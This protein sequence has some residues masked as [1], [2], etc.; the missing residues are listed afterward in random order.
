MFGV[1]RYLLVA[2]VLLAGGCDG[3]RPAELWSTSLTTLVTGVATDVA[4]DVSDTFFPFTSAPFSAN[5]L[6]RANLASSKIDLVTEQSFAIAVRMIQAVKSTKGSLTLMCAQEGSAKLTINDVTI[7]EDLHIT[8]FAG[9]GDFSTTFFPDDAVDGLPAC[10]PAD[11]DDAAESMNEVKLK[12]E[13]T[14]KLSG[15]NGAS[16]SITIPVGG[17]L[18]VVRVADSG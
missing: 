18:T 4:D 2:T 5:Q 10:R 6:P 3:V 16:G 7:V 9:E 13:L 12:I 11:D 8:G 14:L 15:E 17:T 1:A